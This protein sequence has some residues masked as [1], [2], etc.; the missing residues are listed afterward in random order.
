MI[1]KKYNSVLKY[2]FV[3]AASLFVVTG[4]VQDDKYNQPNLDGY[5]CAD[6]KGIVVPFADVKA[7][8]VP[9]GE[10][11]VFPEDTTPNN[12]SD[13][14]YMV[15]YVSSSDE[16]GNIYKT[17]YIQ[18]A[19]ENPT[20]GF[21]ISVDAVSN[22]T[23]YPQGSKVYVKLNGLA[24]G[25][26]GTLVQLGVKTGTEIKGAVSRI[27]EKLVGKYIFRSCAP[28]GN[29]VPKVMKLSDMTAAND[30]YFGCLIE[31]ND[32]EF[33]AR[34]LCTTYAPNGVTVDKTIGEGWANGKY[35][36]TAV[37]RNSGYASFA[38]QMIPSG[39][40][41]FVGI[42]S[43][44]TTTYQLYINK[45]EDLKMTNFPR[46]DGLNSGPCDFDQSM[47]TPKTV[48]EIKQLAAGTTN[49][50]QITG[51]FSLK[52]QV[53][54]NDETGNLYKYVYV[55]DATGGIR[56]NMNKTNLYLDSRFR[57]GKDV[58]IKLKNLYVRSVNGE[59]QLGSLF[60]NNTQ[61]GQ[62]EEAE[63]YKY[64][65]DSNT[66]AR[67]VV[68]TEKTISQLTM[69]DVGRWIK[70][71]DVQFVN[72][73]LGK[74]L[75]DGTNVTSR[76]L[77]DCSGNTIVLRT[78]GQAKFGNYVPGSYEVKGGKGDVYAALSVY[79]GTYQLWITRLA[80]IDFD[81]P[82][83]DGSIYTPLPV[84][85]SD[86]FSAGGFGSDWTVVNKVGPNQFWQSVN[87]GGNGS[88]YYA[89]MN[90]NSGG[91]IANE[92]WLIS[93][94]VS[95]VGKT[96]AAVSFTSDVRYSGNAL[97]VYATDNYTGDV[98]TTNW[99]PLSVTLDTNTGGFGDWVGS[100]N[101]DLSAY[102]GKNVV[103]A[104]KYTSTTS[105]AAT[106]QIDDFKIKGE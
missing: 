91:N 19:L 28:K 101:V 94:A 10:T 37:V 53:V 90:G 6:K 66:T 12:E 38:S 56:V 60:S 7:K 103:I 105:A 73:D 77:E 58:N 99:T 45:S 40:G 33:D 47:L 64:F 71:K 5:D 59:V 96:K 25:N 81:A 26:Y 72:G 16:T 46:L 102:L 67:A 106:W 36:K 97:Q 1:M 24:V 98:G 76:T 9:N 104:F 83:C 57:L 55:E 92:D 80:N 49:W 23:K 69:A 78:S 39:K 31:I 87:L 30:Q 61:F 35:A 62:I 4:C 48:A 22:Y 52:A 74:T 11:Y 44:F 75:T 51:D 3:A 17:I 63:M 42:Y 8:Y 88:N 29:I 54:A 85:Y 82:R 93:K 18:D 2:I 43:K 65:F 50:V 27:P 86:S 100:G 32:V 95:L 68:P 20:H 84:I 13:D 89:Y 21:T 15:G 14:L 34:A 70:I 79:N 41:K